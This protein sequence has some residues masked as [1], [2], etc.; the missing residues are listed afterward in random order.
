MPEN[1][2]G[3][4]SEIAAA[5]VVAVAE[6][7][8]NTPSLVVMAAMEAQQAIPYNEP[9]NAFMDEQKRTDMACSLDNPDA[10]EACGS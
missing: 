1:P 7:T 6:A 10:C 2:A 3:T 9:N 8:V 5:E 4:D